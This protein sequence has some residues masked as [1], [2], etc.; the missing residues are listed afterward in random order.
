MNNKKI[1]ELLAPAG[2]MDSLKAAVSAGADAV[3]LGTRKFGARNLASNFSGDELREAVEYCH[4]RNVR[5]YVTHNTLIHDDEIPDS[6]NE[7]HSLFATGVDAV[8]LQDFGIL[9]AA[10]ILLPGLKLHASTQMTIHNPEGVLW[11][12]KNGI[13]RVVLSREMAAE[14][15]AAIKNVRGSEGAGLEV[16]IHGALC[17]SYSGQCL[18]SSMIGGRSGNRGFCAQ[19]CR[20][21]YEIFSLEFD[22]SG[23]L[24]KK[25]KQDS[26]Y[27]MSPADLCA[28]RNLRNLVGL[29]IDSFKI[30]GRMKSPEYVATVVSVYRKA[31]DNIAAGNWSPSDDD[32]TSLMLAFN[33]GF[34]GGHISGE[35]GSGIMSVDFPANRG[36]HAGTVI[37]Y[38][39]A[40]KK[41]YV[42]T[43]GRVV[44]KAGDG[45]F[46]RQEGRAEDFGLTIPGN[47]EKSGSE[48]I[49][50]VREPVVPGSRVYVTK[51]VTLS[52]T[53]KEIS[54]TPGGIAKKIPVLIKISFKEA[55]PV[56]E[57]TFPSL[58]GELSF[59][60]RAGFSMEEAKSRPVDPDDLKN[61]FCKTGNLQFDVA[62]YVS[63]YKGGLF[64]PISLLNEFR[65]DFFAGIER[66]MIDVC[67]PRKE[68]TETAGEE[69]DI[70]IS[71]MKSCGAANPYK[72]AD[73]GVS[74]YVSGLSSAEA[75]LRGGCSRI[76]YEMETASGADSGTYAGELRDGIQAARKYSAEFIW[77]WPR[78]TDPSFIKTAKSVLDLMGNCS[79]DGIMVENT[80]DGVGVK[81]ISGEILLYGGQGL[82]IFNHL[83]VGMFS[84]DYSLLTISCELNQS[85]L[86]RLCSLACC[87]STRPLMEYSVHGPAELLV[88][89][90]NLPESSVGKRYSPGK[91]YGI[92]DSTGR[93]FPVRVDGYGRTH[94]YNSA[95]TCLIDSLPEVLASGIDGISLDL[96]LFSPE[97]VER[98]V[99]LYKEALSVSK[100]SGK[101]RSKALGRLK[102]E[103]SGLFI[104][105]I[106][107]GHFHRGV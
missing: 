44:P 76:Y 41:V 93:V 96:R 23:N 2:S 6:V 50:H 102:K 9:S 63:N 62:G 91:E 38:D 32:E 80:G 83:A 72:A 17:C 70:F 75:A 81:M 4:S 90:N 66:K 79:P 40:K 74:A 104:G 64:A 30:E 19:P 5:V 11:A 101:E 10:S 54:S 98:I 56:A 15:I 48:L 49:F 45:I 21:E 97:T 12:A 58:H 33:R 55:T 47:A 3:Y 53:A 16:F 27:M 86:K 8:L 88:S 61:I 22:E 82:N 46:F 69:I 89:E 84:G 42:K 106:T 65:R 71:S 18:L 43:D 24:R 92:A 105:E 14:D 51:S 57:A 35:S 36:V 87:L 107:A 31:L 52:K 85:E 77:K 95:V 20:K 39:K 37:R 100:T 60:M 78:I 13:S 59:N 26:C 7:L 68:E 67:M 99:R 25:E 94:V 34:T 103:I 73:P 29:G 28:Y 1:P